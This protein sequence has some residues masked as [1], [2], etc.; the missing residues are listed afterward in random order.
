MV[1]LYII[2]CKQ[3]TA[4]WNK[5]NIILIYAYSRLVQGRKLKMHVHI[6]FFL[7]VY[8]CMLLHQVCMPTAECAY[9]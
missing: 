1:A 5:N 4:T 2:L 8:T 3:V 9:Y 6:N 7:H